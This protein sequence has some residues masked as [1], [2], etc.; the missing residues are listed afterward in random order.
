VGGG[1]GSWFVTAATHDAGI[2]AANSVLAAPAGL[3]MRA[4]PPATAAVF[5]GGGGCGVAYGAIGGR[6]KRRREQLVGLLQRRR[7][8]A[9]PAAAGAAAALQQAG[10][11]NSMVTRG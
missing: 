10:P 9:M 11:M 3:G 1:K 8:G 6:L 5:E 4:D 2:G 7:Q